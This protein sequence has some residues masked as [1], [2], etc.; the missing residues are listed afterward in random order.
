VTST[1][2]IAAAVCRVHGEPLV[3]EQVNLAA[4]GAGDIRVKLLATAICHSDITYAEGGWGGDVPAI[5]G[6]ECA[7]VVESIGDGVSR[8][9]VGDTV[10]VTLIR[11]CGFCHHCLRGRLTSCETPDPLASVSPLT[12]ADGK[13]IVHALHVAGFAEYAVVHESQAVAIPSD[14]G[15]DVASLIACGVITGFGAVTNTAAIEAGSHVVVFGCGGVGLNSIQ[16]ALVSGAQTIIAIDLSDSKLDAA[17]S[18]G[19]THTINAKSDDVLAGVRAATGGRGADYVF[20]TVGAKAAFDQSYGLLAKGGTT[21]LVGMP[22][23]G[24]MSEIDPGTMASYNQ[25]I[26]GSRMGSA[27]IAIDVPAIVSLYRQGRIKLDELITARY[28][29]A[30]INDAIA[31]VNNGVAL[32]NVIVFE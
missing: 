2:N 18:F 23:S 20:V 9:S 4:P 1:I 31:A 28:P 26:I 13:P 27:R 24:V 25:R 12:D 19:A 17:K 11:S 7:G 16:G 10:V 3:I 21:V 8:V 5:Y 6:H 22:A 29:L 32:R 14:I 30:K 15:G